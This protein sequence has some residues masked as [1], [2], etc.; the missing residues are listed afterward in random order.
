M[1]S[2]VG[3]HVPLNVSSETYVDLLTSWG[4][5]LNH[6]FFLHHVKKLGQQPAGHYNSFKGEEAS[7]DGFGQLLESRDKRFNIPRMGYIYLCG[8]L[9]YVSCHIRYYRRMLA[10]L[11]LISAMKKESILCSRKVFV[12]MQMHSN[13]T[14]RN[15]TCVIL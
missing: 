13:S 12:L 5:V 8:V 7:L 9:S 11:A 4:R 6:Q 10:S 2:Q 14:L 1:Q 15:V 3:G